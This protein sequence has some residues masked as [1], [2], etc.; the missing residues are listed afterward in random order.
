MNLAYESH[1]AKHS[2]DGISG[3]LINDPCSKEFTIYRGVHTCTL[4]IMTKLM[5]LKL[6]WPFETHLG[7]NYL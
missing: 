1:S 7:A 6:K 2:G 4:G 5:W 3:R